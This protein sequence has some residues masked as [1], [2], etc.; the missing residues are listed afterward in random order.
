MNY[1]LAKRLKAAGFFQ[2]SAGRRVAPTDK[3]VARR[4]DFAYAPTLEELI[5][6]LP[7]IWLENRAK[8]EFTVWRSRGKWFAAYADE[9]REPAILIDQGVGATPSEAVARLWLALR[10][11]RPPE[12]DL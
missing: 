11:K 12:S 1:E 6:S 4:E 9:Y 3:I 2:E 7:E 5:R 10:E 8:H